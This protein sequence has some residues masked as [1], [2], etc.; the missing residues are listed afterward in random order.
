MNEIEKYNKL[1]QEYMSI[2]TP[3]VSVNEENE[4]ELKEKKKPRKKTEK[5][6]F[7]GKK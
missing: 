1:I 7:F 3:V 2:K 5:E 4:I 6:I